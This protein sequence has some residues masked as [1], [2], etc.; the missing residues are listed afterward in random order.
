MCPC[1]RQSDERVLYVYAHLVLQAL[2]TELLLSKCQ[3]VIDHLR[4]RRAVADRDV[5]VQADRVV[6]EIAR[7]QLGQHLSIPTDEKRIVAVVEAQRVRL[8]GERVVT[9]IRHGVERRQ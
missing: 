5:E 1:L 9:H 2:Q 3:F 7:E 6:R 8:A 4:L